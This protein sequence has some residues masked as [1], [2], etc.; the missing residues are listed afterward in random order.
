MDGK[1][2]STNYFIRRAALSWKDESTFDGKDV[3]DG[4]TEPEI[5]N[6][7]QCS[8]H[9]LRNTF[10]NHL[11]VKEFWNCEQNLGMY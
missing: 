8:K 5:C 7:L 1:N 10:K 3:I 2:D 11:G 9:R 6:H 4:H